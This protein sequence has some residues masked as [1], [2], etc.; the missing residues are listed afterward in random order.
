MNS[1]AGTTGVHSVYELE[2]V[3]IEQWCYAMQYEQSG[4]T[5]RNQ[6][7][8]LRKK[9]SSAEGVLRR[10]FSSG[11]GDSNAMD[12]DA[13]MMMAKAKQL[14]GMYGEVFNILNQVVSSSKVQVFYCTQRQ[15]HSNCAIFLIFCTHDDVGDCNAWRF[16][17]CAWRQGHSTGHCR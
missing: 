9:V 8:D 4:S 3:T 5:S 17:L 2:A 7:N 13:L 6:M 11:S 10:C 1:A 14:L 15:F 16:L 12:I